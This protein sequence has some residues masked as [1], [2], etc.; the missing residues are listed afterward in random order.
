MNKP[1]KGRKPEYRLK[2]LRKSTEET[3]EQG[4][5][6]VN[7]NGSITI[8]LNLCAVIHSDPDLLVTLFPLKP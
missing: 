2:V 6:W 1:A 7:E 5:G 3:A 4:A 8:R